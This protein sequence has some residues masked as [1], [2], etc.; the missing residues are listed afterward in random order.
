MPFRRTYASRR[1][2]T[3]AGRK[4]FVR[5]RAP[6][7]SRVR[8]QRP[9][10]RAQRSQIA[11]IAR[12]AVRNSKILN[13]S[14]VYCDWWENEE[15]TDYNPV[16][17][18]PIELT[19]IAGWRP[20]ARQSQIVSRERNTFVRDMTFNYYVSA[21]RMDQ[22]LFLSMFI[23]TLRPTAVGEPIPSPLVPA[24]FPVPAPPPVGAFDYT[25]QGSEQSIILNSAKYRVLWTR[26]FHLFPWNQ[27]PINQ[28]DEPIPF[29]DPSTSFR[30]GRINLRL[31]WNL[32][33]KGL[34]F[35]KD[36]GIGDLP[37]SRRMYLLCASYSS[38]TDGVWELSWG[39]KFTTINDS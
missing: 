39:T 28:G 1:Q 5:R 32:R 36:I 30:R 33:S 22:P 15:L 19:D 23:V 17:S 21:S 38:S 10:A 27:A 35:W 29:G 18:F 2:G 37:P 34:G 25:S 31:N 16:G 6:I 8:Y 20:G 11:S 14:K 9:T 12:M 7:A 13:Q 3:R 24:Q 4:P 26:S